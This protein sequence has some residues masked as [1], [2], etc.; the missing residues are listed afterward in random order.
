MHACHQRIG[1]ASLAIVLWCGGTVRAEEANVCEYQRTWHTARD[2]E[3]AP[4]IFGTPACIRMD[5]TG[6]IYVLDTQLQEL[7]RFGPEGEYH[8]RIIG[9][10]EGPGDLARCYDFEIWP[11]DR[12]AVP[13]QRGAVTEFDFDG[14]FVE[15]LVFGRED[16]VPL[17][18]VLSAERHG[19]A[20]LIRGESFNPQA[21]SWE[22]VLGT[23][24]VAGNV[25]SELCTKTRPQRNY[26][27]PTLTIREADAFFAGNRFVLG[28]N[29]LVY[30]APLRDSFDIVSYDMRGRS[31]G[32]IDLDWPVYHR[33]PEEIEATKRQH[34]L[35]GTPGVKLPDIIYDI[36]AT[37]PMIRLLLWV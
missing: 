22:S 2:D 29:G 15:S 19:D 17:G 1:L 24:S 25:L 27:V 37:A 36:E 18:R 12:L 33:T 31:V 16:P 35:V 23:Y 8:G 3:R 20:F 9:S 32:R 4:Y 14:T 13:R 28:G 26:S 11:G 30:V 10:G 21:G 34:G 5:D 7:H 6:R